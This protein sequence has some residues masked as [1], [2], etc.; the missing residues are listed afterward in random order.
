MATLRY[1]TSS[2]RLTGWRYFWAKTVVGFNPAVHCAQC[3]VGAYLKQVGKQMAVN[4][5]VPFD[6]KPGELVYFC[7]VSNPYVWKNNLHLAVVGKLG[8][9]ATAKAYNGDELV[10]TGAEP[11]KILPD[12]AV[13]TYATRGKEFLTC[14][15]YQFGAQVAKQMPTAV[16]V[17]SSSKA[18]PGQ[19]T[20]LI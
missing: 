10:V 9:V 19:S 3:L 13:S 12:E 18:A 7:G 11:I 17:P 8:A 1:I 6:L 5:N 2:A 20:L 14:R 4:Q 16:R 15:N